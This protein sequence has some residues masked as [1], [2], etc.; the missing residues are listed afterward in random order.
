MDEVGGVIL[1]EYNSPMNELGPNQPPD[2]FEKTLKAFQDLD[3]DLYEVL[4]QAGFLLLGP[5]DRLA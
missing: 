2:E 5:E 3:L 1:C 4:S